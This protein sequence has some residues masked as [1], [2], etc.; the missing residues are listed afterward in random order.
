MPADPTEWA[1]AISFGIAGYAVL[2]VPYFLLVD[3]DPADFDPRP[4]LRRA[5][6]S[7]RLDPALIAVVN[8]RH[9]ARDTAERARR[10]PRD[11]AITAA[12]LLMLLTATPEATR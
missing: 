1:A 12:A 8:T 2:S 4:A 6:E 11:T 7:G 9:T 10:I 3:A 5:I